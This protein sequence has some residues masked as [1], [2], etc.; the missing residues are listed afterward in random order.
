MRQQA[1]EMEAKKRAQQEEA[2]K[3]E[4]AKKRAEEA[5]RKAEEAVSLDAH[6]HACTQ[7]RERIL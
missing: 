3:K 4:E 2:R 7:S 6:V 1:L 5:R